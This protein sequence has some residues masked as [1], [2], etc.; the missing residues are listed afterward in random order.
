ME[1]IKIIVDN[2]IGSD[3]DDTLC[4]AYL[5][6]EPRCE[7]LGITTGSSEPHKRAEIVDTVCRSAGRRVPIF[8]GLGNPIIGKQRQVAVHQYPIA[9]SLERTRFSEEN[10][11]IDFMR[12]TIE[13]YPGEVV[14][15]A[16]GPP[17]NIGALFAAYP[18]LSGLVR[19]VAFLGGS[20]FEEGRSFLRTEW[21]IINDP[22]ATEIIFKSGADILIAG[23][24]ISLRTLTSAGQFLKKEHKGVMK[25]VAL[26]T[27]KFIERTDDMYYHDVIVAM[28]LFY[29]DIVKTRRGTLSV[30]L[31]EEIGRTDFAPCEDGNAEIIVDLD[32]KRFFEIYDKTV[33]G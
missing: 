3:I 29:E 11:A 10:T 4:L 32:L 13:K 8:P 22:Y 24:D 27:E 21:N 6:K 15:L 17:T 19:R 30:D 5:L 23:L 2:D 31:T 12:E 33:N 14:L 9:E 25:T 20:F 7:L 18:H 16:I 28:A 26:Y 1:K